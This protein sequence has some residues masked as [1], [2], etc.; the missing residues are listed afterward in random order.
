MSRFSTATYRQL[1]VCF[2]LG[3]LVW[4]GSAATAQ[5]TGPRVLSAS[6][7]QR[8]TLEE[9]LVNRLHA[10]ADDQQQYLHY[11][12]GQVNQGHLEA[13]LVI[14]VLQYAVRRNPQLPFLF[15]ERAMKVESTKR[16]VSLPT[17]RQFATVA[18]QAGS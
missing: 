16:G 12:V 8:A 1:L 2:S 11:V 15:F 17:V 10:T 6:P 14:A 5:I 13:R 4:C 18:N 9:L 3:S 7:D